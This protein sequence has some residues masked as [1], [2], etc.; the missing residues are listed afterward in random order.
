MSWK[1]RITSLID[2]P[3]P[4]GTMALGVVFTDGAREFE[5]SFKLQAGQTTDQVTAFL[6]GEVAKLDTLDKTALDL[7]SMIGTEITA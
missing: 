4:N 5:K 3:V 6:A 2:N 7:S 1:A